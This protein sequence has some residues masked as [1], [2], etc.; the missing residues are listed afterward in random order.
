M[1]DSQFKINVMHPSGNHW[2]WPTAEDKIFYLRQ[3]ITKLIN[4]PKA[5]GNRGQFHFD[6]QI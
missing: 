1:E 5:A 3:N 2:K 6:E 4:P